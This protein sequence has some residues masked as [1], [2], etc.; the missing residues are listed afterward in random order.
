[1]VG[2]IMTNIQIEPN[3]RNSYVGYVLTD[4]NKP[5]EIN[6][7]PISYDELSDKFYDRMFKDEF[8]DQ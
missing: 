2:V 5:I 7:T 8:K 4:G 1:M 3:K 6:M